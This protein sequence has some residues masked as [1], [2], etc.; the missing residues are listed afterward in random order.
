MGPLTP[1]DKVLSLVDET[2]YFYRFDRMPDFLA[3]ARLD[4]LDVEFRAQIEA[5]WR[6]A[7]AECGSQRLRE[8]ERHGFTPSDFAES[9]L[10]AFMA[11][12]KN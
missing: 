6:R 7:L 2:G 4:E 5:V 9:E 8:A 11:A 10:A 3:H 12:L 1:R